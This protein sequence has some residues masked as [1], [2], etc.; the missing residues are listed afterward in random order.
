MCRRELPVRQ[1]APGGERR[2]AARRD[3]TRR[4]PGHR[5]TVGSEIESVAP[6]RRLSSDREHRERFHGHRPYRLER[7]ATVGYEPGDH[8]RSTGLN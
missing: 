2:S 7:F 6:T 1:Q 3:G 5:T 4:V 8:E